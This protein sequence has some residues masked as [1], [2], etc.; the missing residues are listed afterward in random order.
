MVL[1]PKRASQI[2]LALIVLVTLVLSGGPSAIYVKL[3]N[4]A[5]PVPEKT[6]FLPVLMLMGLHMM[7]RLREVVLGSLVSWAWLGVAL[8]ALAST[9]WS[10]SPSD[11]F[12]EAIVMVVA[13]PWIA[14]IAT[15]ADWRDIVSR[16]WVAC[17]IL[18]FASVALYG[19]VPRLGQ[20]QDIY[21]G[22]FIGLW[23]EKNMTGQFLSVTAMLS[24][25]RLAM[26]PRTA[27]S[28]IMIW[29][30]SV[31]LLVPAQSA[32]SLVATGL[33]SVLVLWVYVMRRHFV[34]SIP[35]LVATILLAAPIGLLLVGVGD[36][37]LRTLGKSG[38]LSGRV[39]IWDALRDYA[40]SERPRWGHG[41]DAYWSDAYSFGQRE[42][43]F[44]QLGFEARHA[45]NALMEMRLA[46]G[47]VGTFFWLAAAVQGA[48]FAFLRIRSSS[49]AYLAIPFALSAIP[50]AAV[51]VS[52]T[53][54]ANVQGML[55]V[56]IVAKMSWLPSEA[57]RTYATQG[58]L[59]GLTQR[60]QAQPAL[61]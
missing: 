29:G 47:S 33:A 2:E 55:F 22:A 3:F 43:I 38:T 26:H 39:P 49:G 41:Y 15:I 42:L 23:H 8:L 17:V 61:A 25:A 57:D 48:L 1:L 7:L 14:M 30:I 40:L 5:P 32:T 21:A 37:V 16:M 24:L 28:S 6:V 59:R 51:E 11:T 10:I 35:G 13:V 46:L 34:I 12:R 52:L 53:S 20:M 44:D 9:R 50:F 18:L 45:H 31:V 36:D 58:V 4:Y 54:V 27:L 60:P 19:L 56:L